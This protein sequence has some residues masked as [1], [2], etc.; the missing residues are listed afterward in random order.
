LSF[1]CFLHIFF[2]FFPLIRFSPQVTSAD[3]LP[4]GGR[5][6]DFPLYSSLIYL[7]RVKAVSTCRW[8][9]RTVDSEVPEHYS[10]RNLGTKKKP[11]LIIKQ[12]QMKTIGTVPLKLCTLFLI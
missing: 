4:T 1:L 11:F 10:T 2:Y 7:L 9:G 3:I 8:L 12:L 5:E 6:G